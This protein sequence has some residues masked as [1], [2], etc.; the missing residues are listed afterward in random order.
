MYTKLTGETANPFS[1][2]GLMVADTYREQIRA[3]TP[4]ALQNWVDENLWF[5]EFLKNKR[6]SSVFF[7][8]SVVVL[9]GFLVTKNQ[10]S[11]PKKWPID[12]SYLEDLY[13]ALG[14]STDGIF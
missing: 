3:L 1:P 2:L 7:C 13:I 12:S 10:S 14:I 4:D 6:E 11:V 8:D 5:G 9:L